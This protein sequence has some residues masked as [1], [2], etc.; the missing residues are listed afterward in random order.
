MAPAR[1]ASGSE[2]WISGESS[3]DL[4]ISN[5]RVIFK[6]KAPHGQMNR[7]AVNALGVYEGSDYPACDDSSAGK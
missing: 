5:P 2:E 3:V 6:S 4:D 1:A 7:R